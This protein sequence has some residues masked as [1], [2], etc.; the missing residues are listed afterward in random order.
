MQINIQIKNLNQIK[1]ALSKSPVLVAKHINR[2]IRRSILDVRNE[3]IP[4]TPVDTGNL[5][6]SYEMKFGQLRGVVSPHAE[7]AYWVEVLPYRHNV[8]QSHYLEAG[9]NAAMN[10]VN[11]NFKEGLSDALEEIARSSK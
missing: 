10:K 7:Y 8:G 5:H 11:Q 2:A 3:A 4:R 9:V 1:A 6:G